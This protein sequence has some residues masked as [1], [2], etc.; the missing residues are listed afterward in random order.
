M[1]LAFA[2]T[3]TGGY[4]PNPGQGVSG[5]I[6]VPPIS[7]DFDESLTQAAR[8]WYW[9]EVACLTALSQFLD[10]RQC[11]LLYA[12]PFTPSVAAAWDAVGVVPPIPPTPAPTPW[13]TPQPTPPPTPQPV[14]SGLDTGQ[15]LEQVKGRC[16]CNDFL[17]YRSTCWKSVVNGDC[18]IAGRSKTKTLRKMWRSFCL[19]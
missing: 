19:T 12:G 18:D 7:F 5:S 17:R 2:L 8:I 13:P 15:C 16:S 4:H 1:N 10:A 6:Y 9:A 3:V 14:G 11:T